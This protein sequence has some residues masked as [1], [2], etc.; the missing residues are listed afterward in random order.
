MKRA[1]HGIRHFIVGLFVL[2][3]V[4]KPSELRG[5]EKAFQFNGLTY[6]S[7]PDN[8]TLDL[9]SNYTIEAW[10]KVDDTTNNTI[11]DKGN[12]RF[13]FQTHSNGN[14]GL[15]LYRSGPGWIY[16]S[17]T[18]PVNEWTH[19]A[20]SVAS[21]GTVKFYKNAQ[22][23]S[24]H[25]GSL[26]TTDDGL[27]NIGRQDPDGCQCNLTNGL[28][29][30][31]RIWNRVRTQQEIQADFNKSIDGNTTGLLAY[32]KF[33][34]SSGNDVIDS[35]QSE[36]N[37]AVVGTATWVDSS[38][39][40]SPYVPPTYDLEYFKGGLVAWYPFDGNASD[41]SGNGNHGTV[42]GATLGTD[43]HGQANKA[44]SFDG[45]NDYIGIN[46]YKGILNDNTRSVG[47]WIN[48]SRISFQPI[49]TWGRP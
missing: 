21:D 41:M 30:E 14:S 44:Y 9:I 42:N 32:W 8:G 38:A 24:S 31:I 5:V 47:C 13:L 17:G 4:S 39:P 27:I 37:G 28:Y 26:G 40:V 19:A 20:V 1:G 6:I 10:L 2:I 45:V 49:V 43:R 15:G 29:D 18:I 46:N 12:Y 33:N 36:N 48:P 7:V 25:N 34:Q 16:S 3:Q 11:I 22:F 35:S 23:L